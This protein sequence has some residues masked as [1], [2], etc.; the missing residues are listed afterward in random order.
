MVKI[1]II[2]TILSCIMPAIGADVSLSGTVNDID[3]V[4]I[5]GAILSLKKHPYLNDETDENG[6]FEIS[7][8]FED[9]IIFNSTGKLI[10]IH[11]FI[12]NNYLTFENNSY[13]KG[14]SI[15]IFNSRGAIVSHIE[16][17]D[18]SPGT[19]TVFLPRT[20]QGLYLIKIS[21]GRD[22]YTLNTLFIGMEQ[23]SASSTI[24]E[25]SRKGHALSKSLADSVDTIIVTATCFTDTLVEIESY[26][27]QNMEII[28][29]ASGPWIPSGYLE[30]SGNMVKVMA[31]GYCFRMGQPDPDICWS[32]QCSDNEQP[33]H[34]VSFTYDFWMDTTEVTQGDFD[35]L[36]NITYSDNYGYF[37]PQWQNTYG[38]GDNYPVYNIGWE[39]MVLYCNARSK[40][41]GYDTI[42]AYD[43]ISGYPGSLC[44]LIGL[45]IDISKNGYRLPTEAEWEYACRAGTYTD[46]YWGKDYDPY[47][48]T[49]ADTAEISN[50]TAW[51]AN[52]WELGLEDPNYGTHIAASHE[53]N[54]YGLYDMSGNV[55]E[56]CNDW[57]GSYSSDIEVDPTGPDQGSYRVP[58]GGSWGNDA[59]FLRSTNRTFNDAVYFYYILGF[60]VVLPV[61]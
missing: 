19:H 40:R 35:N 43:S 59:M 5:P 41:D 51:R 45:S 4:A 17:T 25:K 58:R 12:K 21:L 27:Q 54:A 48:S 8:D 49:T 39:D 47:P 31:N 20:A 1:L 38:L 11:P 16:L 13:K 52:S 3:G 56:W 18:L 34:T 26:N 36:M 42:Y 55:Y 60:R 24:K 61:R 15:D 28:L 53:P 9:A 32:S 50:Y 30:Y 10:S 46:F 29:S 2:I 14:A 44:E 33:V 37:T 57:F 23:P 22:I 6:I 7:G